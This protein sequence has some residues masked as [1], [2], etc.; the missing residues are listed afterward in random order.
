MQTGKK[1]GFQ[2]WLWGLIAVAV[3][4]GLVGG[5]WWI[6]TRFQST[7][8]REA[9]A[10]PPEPVAVVTP[11][12]RGDLRDDFTVNANVSGQNATAVTFAV[13]SEGTTVVT[14]LGADIGKGRALNSGQ[15]LLWAND[16]PVIALDGIFPAYR[17]LR[18]GD[19]GR[20]VIQLQTAFAAMGYQVSIDGVLGEETIDAAKDLYE[21]NGVQ[22]PLLEKGNVEEDDGVD[23]V[24]QSGE[25]DIKRE[26]EYEYV[27]PQAEICYVPSLS[28]LSVRLNSVPKVGAIL[29]AATAEIQIVGSELKLTAEVPGAVAAA[30][31]PGLGAS[32]IFKQEPIEL[33]VKEINPIE[34]TDDKESLQGQATNNSIVVFEPASGSL[35]EG[36][37]PEEEILVTVSRIEALEDALIVPK[38]AIS[39]WPDSN[40]F[41]LKKNAD[42]GFVETAVS[43]LA[44]VSGECAVKAKNGDLDENDQIRVDEP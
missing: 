33:T 4:I 44:C 12:K 14:A 19:E 22:L 16:R 5:T 38:R 18:V 1:A 29:D 2:K 35:P 36:L 30:L 13:S 32:F 37:N 26:K 11:V 27:I 21:K 9:A 17:D 40:T 39:S 15:V 25:Q 34:K 31:S 10:K 41:V 7:A 3:G 6:A 42:G 23:E 8:Q 20:D 43:E 28:S 24:P